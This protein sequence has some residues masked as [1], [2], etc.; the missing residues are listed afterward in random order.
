MALNT[1]QYDDVYA[2]ARRFAIQIAQDIIDDHIVCIEDC[3]D[4]ECAGIHCVESNHKLPNLINKERMNNLLFI[5]KSILFSSG[6]YAKLT[7]RFVK[8]VAHVKAEVQN[9][10]PEEYN[11]N[12]AKE[13]RINKEE[14]PKEDNPENDLD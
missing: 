13:Y 5:T 6:Y 14:N 10:T 9:M 8:G 1:K 7:G 11:D 12:I 3:S 4:D 2:S